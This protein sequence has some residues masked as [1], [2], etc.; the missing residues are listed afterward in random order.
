M[1]YNNLKLSFIDKYKN[2]EIPD[3]KLKDGI[4]IIFTDSS[5]YNEQSEEML[6]VS[7]RK[8]F[9]D[10]VLKNKDTTL[11]KGVYCSELSEKI[12][13]IKKNETNNFKIK[14]D[15]PNP[16]ILS[17]SS[18]FM[19]NREM[20]IDKIELM[21]NKFKIK[22]D[23]SENDFSCKNQAEK[24]EFKLLSHQN[25]VLE[26]LK[27]DTPYRGLLL[28]HGLGSGKT[29]SAIA[30][31]EGLKSSQQIIIMT[32]A[33]LQTNFIS[34]L[35]KC[36]DQ[37]Y[38]KLQNWE[39]VK[40]DGQTNLNVLSKE[41]MVHI[42]IIEKKKGV[43]V[44]HKNRPANYSSNTLTNKD[45]ASIDE[46]ILHMIGRQYTT[47]NYN[48]GIKSER[49]KSIAKDS[50]RENPF[51]DKVVIIDEAHNFISRIVNKL[52]KKKAQKEKKEKKETSKSQ[53]AKEVFDKTISGQLYNYLLSARNVRIVLLTGT[54]IVN[55]P[56]EA[57]ILFNI[58]RGYTKTWTIKIE[59]ITN[60]SLKTETISQ[61][62]KNNG[63]TL[64]D[65]INYTG[66]SLTVTRN[67]YGFTNGKQKIPITIKKNTSQINQNKKKGGK[68]NKIKTRKNLKDI[69]TPYTFLPEIQ[70]AGENR[71]PDYIGVLKTLDITSDDEFI[72]K[73][74]T[75]LEKSNILKFDEKNEIIVDNFLCLPD[76]EESFNKMFINDQ[77]NMIN[78]P[79]FQRR[80]LG[81]TSY[82][83]SA[84]ENLL[85]E[86]EK[87]ENNENFHIERCEMSPHQLLEYSK[88]RKQEESEN[89]KKAAI[90]INGMAKIKSSYKIFSRACCNFA[91][92]ESIKRPYPSEIFEQIKKENN[93]DD[94]DVETLLRGTSEIDD[95]IV[96]DDV[97]NDADI[98]IKKKELQYIK[99]YTD[100][101]DARM[102]ILNDKKFLHI[103]NLGEFSPK[104]K[105]ILENVN[106]TDNKGLHLIYSNFRSIEGIAILKAV[107]EMND[108]DEFILNKKNGEWIIEGNNE[109][110]KFVLYT[111][112]ESA[113]KKEI[114]RN[115]YNGNW[116]TFSPIFKKQLQEISK[117]N[118]YG[119]VIKILMITSSGAEG[120][121][122]K[123]T[124]YIH[125]V[126]PFWHMVRLNQVVGRARRICSHE[127]LPQGERTVKVFVYLATFSEDQMNNKDD[128]RELMQRE[129][130]KSKETKK[131]ITTDEL[132][133]ESAN[134]KELLNQQI[135]L[136]I[137]GTAIDC[138][139]YQDESS[140]ENYK[141]LT[142]SF[143]SSSNEF[144]TVP[145]IEKD[146]E[147]IVFK[148]NLET[149]TQI[150]HSFILNDKTYYR[151]FKN[152]VY[153]I[154]P[155]S[156]DK[157]NI[158][159]IG[160]IETKNFN[161][162]SSINGFKVF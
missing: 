52:P 100:L 98:K 137:K 154:N 125:I 87:N 41:T 48:G 115:I 134:R 57:A 155:S 19:N 114:I 20:F 117:N 113:E 7:S 28:F 32:P 111:G 69:D 140:K 99:L 68:N 122:L 54:P 107:F 160:Q 51:D 8:L 2:R 6:D 61:I 128:Y 110:K 31:A 86:Y 45:R 12:K 94:I 29:C 17:D 127:E 24:K 139:L 105:K 36:G 143:N 131:S 121:N 144:L 92:P 146:K 37:L 30:I 73:L 132:L 50:G 60:N 18:Y 67:P 5:N 93:V 91:F 102:K 152:Y 64:H 72:I 96:N 103:D 21:L 49:L 77:R 62:L 162:D 27:Y 129:N 34:E 56:N 88:I 65:Y 157:K 147:K 118:L 84:Q 47:L 4:S 83:R 58:L 70:N 85:P 158:K 14:G 150:Y 43:W 153:D 101:V 15:V 71:I 1:E 53:K 90:D 82:F 46:Q 159:P 120:I 149:K 3:T 145:D 104:F 161:A 142:T 81:L 11:V 89:K 16:I 38:K 9:L 63:F 66:S 136:A 106:K 39:F 116:D 138:K 112:S 130:D 10:N 156:E 126:E 97:D 33:S 22:L 109:K 55:Y 141:C 135:L 35:Q 42:D 76:D 59:Q 95:D 79:K 75:T 133:F 123:N 13:K 119:E 74:Q 44:I 26:Y 40:I 80:I 124:R 148:Q 23:S 78:I 151:G 25:V 108:Y